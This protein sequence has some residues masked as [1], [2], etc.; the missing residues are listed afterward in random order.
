MERRYAVIPTG[1]DKSWIYHWAPLDVIGYRS[2]LI[3][4]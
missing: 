3:G 1:F 2:P 4:R